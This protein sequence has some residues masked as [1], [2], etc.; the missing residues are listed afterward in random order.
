MTPALGLLILHCTLRLFQNKRRSRR[1]PPTNP[2]IFYAGGASRGTGSGTSPGPGSGTSPG[3]SP[4]TAS[5]TSPGTASGT[6]PGTV[7]VPQA[8]S[9]GAETAAPGTK[10][11]APGTKTAT[12]GPKTLPPAPTTSTAGVPLTPS[13]GVPLTPWETKQKAKA[14]RIASLTA[15]ALEAQKKTGAVVEETFCESYGVLP[16]DDPKTWVLKDIAEKEERM[17]L[18]EF[19]P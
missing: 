10:K 17:T 13:V 14:E 9:P 18:T 5:G 1:E 11:A 15:A 7:P 19:I 6:S 8:V 4:G 3:T 2:N 12:P 16:G